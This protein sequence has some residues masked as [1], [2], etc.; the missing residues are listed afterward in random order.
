[1]S[2]VRSCAAAGLWVARA[3]NA[4]DTRRAVIAGLRGS[5]ARGVDLSA[6]AAGICW[7]WSTSWLLRRP[8]WSLTISGGPTTAVALWRRLAQS[9]RQLRC[10]WLGD[11]S[12][13]GR[14]A[15]S[16]CGGGAA[17]RTDPAARLPGLPCRTGGDTGR[18]KPARACWLAEDAVATA[19][20]S[21]CSMHARGDV[22]SS[23]MPEWP[24]CRRSGTTVS[25]AIAD[26][27]RFLP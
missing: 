7:L 1:M 5:S 23:T 21:S 27:L 18:G 17:R 22:W 3:D 24:S 13:P 6:A 16:L 19:V 15:C 26:R 25:E 11:A 12:G 9:V 14:T 4:A 8:C 20:L 10:Y 2:L